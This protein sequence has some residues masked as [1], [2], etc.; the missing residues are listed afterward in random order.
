MPNPIP[1][2]NTMDNMFFDE[3]LTEDLDACEEDCD[4]DCLGDHA[5]VP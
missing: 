3:E 1:E 4:E 5:G 2:N